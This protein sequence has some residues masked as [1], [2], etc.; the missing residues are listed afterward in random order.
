MMKRIALLMSAAVLFACSEEEIQDTGY[1]MR[2][3]AG[4][5]TGKTQS[6]SLTNG[7]VNVTEVELE[8]ENEIDSLEVEIDIEGLYQFD[9]ITGNSTPAFPSY[10]MPAGTY[11]ELEVQMGDD[12]SSTQSVHLEADYSDT[13]GN[14]VPLIVDIME[15]IELEIEDEV[16][17]IQ[18]QPN[19]ISTLNVVMGI[20]AILN[21]IDLSTATQTNGQILINAQSNT[22]LYTQLVELLNVEIEVEDDD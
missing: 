16:N 5:V 9:L 12:D 22:S 11:T 15:E 21:T 3:Q 20:N 7:W 8:D 17:G 4:E 19:Q 2:V 18:V 14:V 13:A 6:V 10:M 1:T